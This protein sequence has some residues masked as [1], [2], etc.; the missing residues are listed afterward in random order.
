[1]LVGGWLV[2]PQGGI[3]YF[4]KLVDVARYSSLDVDYVVSGVY[5]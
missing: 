3:V 1:L 5:S 4:N 2:L